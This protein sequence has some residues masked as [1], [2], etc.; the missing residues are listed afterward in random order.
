MGQHGEI[1]VLKGH[2]LKKFNYDVTK[3]LHPFNEILENFFFFYK[4]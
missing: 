3:V 4:I 2:C 1:K